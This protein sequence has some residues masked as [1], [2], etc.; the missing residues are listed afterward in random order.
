MKTFTEQALLAKANRMPPEYLA[1]VYSHAVRVA[2]G[3]VHMEDQ[4][5][6]VVRSKYRSIEL[7]VSLPIAQEIGRAH[8]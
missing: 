8:V 4:A 1:D 6:E 5:Y 2:E 3:V 7:L